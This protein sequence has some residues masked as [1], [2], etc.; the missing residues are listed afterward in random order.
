MESSCDPLGPFQ[1][2]CAAG[3]E[4]RFPIICVFVLRTTEDDSTTQRKV[5]QM[6]ETVDKVKWKA[7]GHVEEEE[8]EQKVRVGSSCVVTLRSLRSDSTLPQPSPSCTK[9]RAVELQ[10]QQE[11]R[12][13]LEE[14]V[15][16]LKQQLATEMKVR[17]PICGHSHFWPP[18]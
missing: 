12:A 7:A 6:L 10:L 18:L 14:E 5:A 17:H 16:R 4:L 3:V 13:A 8:E 1:K 11:R 2:V 9:R 15:S